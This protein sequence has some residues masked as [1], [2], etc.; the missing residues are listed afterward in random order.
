MKTQST[1]KIEL[2]PEQMEQ[3]QGLTGK[4]IPK[5]KRSLEALPQV[6][7]RCVRRVANRLL[8]PAA[9]ALA[10]AA[11]LL[12]M[13]SL[14]AAANPA[15]SSGLT[16]IQ[17]NTPVRIGDIDP[18]KPS[19]DTRTFS[20]WFYAPGRDTRAPALLLLNVRDFTHAVEGAQ[21]K[22]NGREV[23]VIHP[24]GGEWNKLST[25]TNPVNQF[26]YTQ[27]IAFDASLLNEGGWNSLEI[28]SQTYPGHTADNYYDDLLLKNVVC[29]YG[30]F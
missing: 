15:V 4:D 10:I 16:Q 12:A 19:E 27:M 28:K 13:S 20:R 29:F 2:T 21:V 18:S 25:N 6:G 30:K 5:V 9:A 1:L 7:P 11:T 3:F 26:W 24:Y 8:A 17:G 22:I 14:P 23:G